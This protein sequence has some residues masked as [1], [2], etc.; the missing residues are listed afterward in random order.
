MWEYIK[1]WRVW[2]LC[3][4]LFLIIEF[5]VATWGGDTDYRNMEIEWVRGEDGEWYHNRP[6]IDKGTIGIGTNLGDVK[7]KVLINKSYL[8]YKID[9]GEQFRLQVRHD[10]DTIWNEATLMYCIDIVW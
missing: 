7:A 9:N 6:D 4:V 5:P 3:L 2:A 8:R 10:V 1:D